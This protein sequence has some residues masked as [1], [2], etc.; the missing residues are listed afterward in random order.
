MNERLIFAGLGV[1]LALVFVLP[2]VSKKVEHNLEVF[3][4]IMGLSSSL[5]SG[6]LG[7]ELGIKALKEPIMISAAVL[8]FGVVFKF[9]KGGVQGAIGAMANRMSIKIF[10]F[11]L[12]VVLGLLSS[13]ITAIIA[14]LLLV[15]VISALKLDRKSEI[16]LVIVA[17]FSIGLGAALT[18]VGE[19]L[20]TIAISK[21]G[22]DFGYLLRA[23]GPYIIPGIL[24]MGAFA[25]LYI[26]PTAIGGQAA[27]RTTPAPTAKE[28][29]K[30]EQEV[31]EAVSAGWVPEGARQSEGARESEGQETLE[32]PEVQES[33]VEVVVRALKVYLFVMAL[34][35]LGEGF[36]PVIDRFVIGLPSAVLYWLNMVSAILDNAT[37]T[38]AEISIKMNALQVKAVLMGLLI[39]GGML[40]PGNIPNIISA[41]KLRIGS[42]EWAS[43]GVP[44]GL[45]VM[46]IYFAILFI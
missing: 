31:E 8:G 38:A 40:I 14:S 41:G 9:L 39:S 23:L 5:I 26:K 18:P 6:V 24:A 33:Y 20:A 37:L 16:R 7:L 21:L 43:L 34:V 2:F 44:L 1:V 42:R 45:A 30:E 12:V 27:V 32:A 13:L 15:E 10:M 29:S 36:K 28:H 35:L 4:F 46:A 22:K 19:P 3:L 17:C 25:A 11:L